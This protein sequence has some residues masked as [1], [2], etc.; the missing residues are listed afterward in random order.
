MFNLWFLL[1]QIFIS[2]FVKTSHREEYLSVKEAILLD[3]L[4]VISHHRA[5]LAT[6]I[7]TIRKMHTAADMENAP[8]GESMYGPGGVGSKRSSVVIEPSYKIY[9]EDKSKSQKSGSDTTNKVLDERGV[10]P[11]AK[12]VSKPATTAKDE[13]EVSGGAEKPKTK[14]SGSKKKSPKKDTT[15]GSTSSVSRSAMEE[16]LV[17]GV[18][19]E[20]SK[21][22][23]PID[24]EEIHSSPKETDAKELTGSTRR[25]GKGTLVAD[26]EKK[27]G[28]SHT[29]A[30]INIFQ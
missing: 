2:C 15:D 1:L 5:R 12:P 7:R 8:F 26:K 21:R 16:N 11:G 22:T 28:Q 29:V 25:S 23:L 20:G 18:A 19:L 30:S 13:A 3:L 6:P 14:R 27:D 17:L 10:K 24:E 4:R 9:G